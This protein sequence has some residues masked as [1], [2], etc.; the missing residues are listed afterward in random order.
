MHTLDLLDRAIHTAKGLGYRVRREWLEGQ[1]GGVC[2]IV[3][4]R[5][6]F[7]D[8]SLSPL[9]QLDQVLEA[10]KSDPALDRVA[11]PAEIDALLSRRRAA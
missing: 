11:V 4:Q 5:W 9:E 6:I 10:L 1:G 3:G 7:L 8:L 2:E